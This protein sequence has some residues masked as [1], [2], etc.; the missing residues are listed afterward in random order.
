MVGD[1]RK[2]VIRDTKIG[3]EGEWGRALFAAYAYA[4]SHHLFSSRT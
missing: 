3:H 4:S 1:K 2:G